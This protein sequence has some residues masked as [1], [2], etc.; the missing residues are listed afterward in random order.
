MNQQSLPY[1][2]SE[3]DPS[4]HSD[5]ATGR[6]RCFVSGCPHWLEPPARKRMGQ[7]CPDHGILCHSSGTYSYANVRRN[8]I[9]DPEIVASGSLGHAGKFE[10]GRFGQERSEDALSWNVFR[11]LQDASLLHE[12]AALM[13]GERFSREPNLYLWGIRLTGDGL[14]QWG[15][16]TAARRRFE[17]NLPVR[18]PLTEPDIALHLPGEYLILIEAKFTSANT[19][20]IK[21]PRCRPADLTVDELLTFYRDPALHILDW[22]A[23][24]CRQRIHYQLW[25]NMVFAEWMAHE[26]NHATRAYHVNLVRAGFE[27]QVAAEFGG[28]L[29]NDFQGRFKRA[30]WEE[31]Y[32]LACGQRDR[33]GLLCQYME[34]K[35]QKLKKAFHTDNSCSP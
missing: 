33:L 28:L 7:V 21:G 35:T 20:Y 19:F 22:D 26:E 6:I 13:T 10:T 32:G 23:A 25:R 17:G 15:L 16:L 1:G 12:V 27:E 30:T 9:A 18:R 8:I 14:E 4:I 2:T 24:D 3:L 5:P 31:L 34:T 29:R 11:S